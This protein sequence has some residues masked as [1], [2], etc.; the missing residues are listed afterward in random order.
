MI[1]FAKLN[2]S[3]CNHEIPLI[4]IL[5]SSSA[6]LLLHNHG[7]LHRMHNA[8]HI[9]EEPHH[10]D[11]TNREIHITMA[12]EHNGP[13]IWNLLP[14]TILTSLSRAVFETPLRPAPS[15]APASPAS[16]SLPSHLFPPLPPRTF[17][18]TPSP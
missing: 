8:K 4:L 6:V 17:P 11:Q 1:F 15:F 9:L 13:H 18:S 12:D 3:F 5:V 16:H 14:R 2:E 7:K 10:K